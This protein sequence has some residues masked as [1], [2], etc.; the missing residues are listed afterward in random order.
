MLTL[1]IRDSGG[2]TILEIPDAID[3]HLDVVLAKVS[4]AILKY[5]GVIEN[6]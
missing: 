3:E 6:G 2:K 5:A 4:E 1:V